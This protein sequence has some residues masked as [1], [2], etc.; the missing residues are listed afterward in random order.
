MGNA[1]FKLTLYGCVVSVCCIGFAS[2]DVVSDELYDCAWN[3]CM[4]Q[5]SDKCVY[6]DCVESFA[7]IEGHSDCWRRGNHFP[8]LR[9]YLMS[10]VPSL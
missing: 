9:C 5:P 7:R 2:L 8:L 3:V 4:Y 6:V 1:T 10:V